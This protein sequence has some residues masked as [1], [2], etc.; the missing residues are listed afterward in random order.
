MRKIVIWLL[1][2]AFALSCLPAVAE[3]ML[4]YNEGEELVYT[5]LAADLGMEN[6]EESPVMQAYRER[7][8]HN[9]RIEWTTLG[10]D[11]W[12]DRL[13]VMCNAGNIPDILW[14]TPVADFIYSYGSYGMFL[15]LRDYAEYMPNWMEI[16]ETRSAYSSLWGENDEIYAVTDV[17]EYD[18][19]HE[20]FFINQT[21]LDE[22]GAEAPST[23][24]EAIALMEQY[25]ALYP[26]SVPFFTHMKSVEQAIM[27][28]LNGRTGMFFNEETNAWDHALLAED[29]SHYKAIVE[30]MHEMYSK[31]L[32]SPEYDIMTDEQR[33]QIFSAGNWLICWSTGSYPGG[34]F[35]YDFDAVPYEVSNLL[36]PTL[37]E[38]DTR[39][40][41][42]N[43]RADLPGDYGYLISANVEQPEVMCSLLD[44]MISEE[45]SLL[46][47]WGIEGET[48]EFNENG[49]PEYIGEYATDA[50]AR[51]DAGIYNFDDLRYIMY[52]DRYSD[53]ARMSDAELE[54]YRNLNEFFRS[55]QVEAWIPAR[56]TPVMNEEQ[57]NTVAM[58]LTPISTYI[59]ENVGLFVT[60][61]RDLSEWDAFVEEAMSMGDIE[62]VKAA[63]EAGRQVIASDTRNWMEF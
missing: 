39:Y 62:A 10:W 58:N 40:N 48:Y 56:N 33:M 51:L 31:G 18:V 42:V 21:A 23:W 37:N 55:G 54:G 13:N 49:K 11:D 6:N 38:G 44:Y 14:V 12:L 1:L 30:L 34:A 2:A 47:N 32:I 20:T 61:D 36:P 17:D 43:F 8:G 28:S 50:Q 9:V 16:N 29:Q 41:F 25:K 63:Y 22:L 52:K 57:R 26:D 19:G 35:N 53:F 46:F 45:A 3:T 4:P 15:N 59:T 24:A 60:G 7:T 27:Y 5:G